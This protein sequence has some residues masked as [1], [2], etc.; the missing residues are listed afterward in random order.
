ME[1]SYINLINLRECKSFKLFEIH[2]QSTRFL[3]QTPE[4][5]TVGLLQ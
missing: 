5:L 2:F 4:G 3:L 1:E